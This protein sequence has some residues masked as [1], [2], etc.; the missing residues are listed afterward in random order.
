M[1]P[2]SCNLCDSKTITVKADHVYG[3]D[4]S[5]K[6]FYQ[7]Q[8][9]DVVFQFP[10]FSKEEEDAFY[11]KNFER[12]MSNRSGNSAWLGAKEH[13]IA[14]EATYIR[15]SKFLNKWI[16]SWNDKDVL[17][18]GCS[19]GFMLFPIADFGAKVYGIE[20]S[21]VFSEFLLDSGVHL[22]SNLSEVPDESMD[23]IMH[24]FVMEH[25]TDVKHWLL[26]QYRILKPGGAILIEV[27]S[28]DDPLS[29]VFNNTAFH[30]F[31]WSVVHPWY[32]NRKSVEFLMNELKL[33][34]VEIKA[35]QRYGLKNH[36][37]WA[38]KNSP[39]MDESLGHISESVDEEYKQGLEKIGKTDTLLIKI[40]KL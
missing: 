37:N 28:C 2:N 24:F 21:A 26:E 40:N 16:D 31:Y 1:L 13:I 33:S 14:N 19:S 3:D 32:F 12:Y 38:I 6:A 20:P 8:N 10:F 4:T 17:E 22:Y 36:F 9:C 23:V 7:C 11:K 15:R 34:D 30:K 25:I 35:Y 18:I 27:P 29:T 39:G 5:A